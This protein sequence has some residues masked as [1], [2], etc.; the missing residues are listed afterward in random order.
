MACLKFGGTCENFWWVTKIVRTKNGFALTD[1]FAKQTKF[2]VVQ[3][4]PK[5]IRLLGCLSW[6]SSQVFDE[7]RENW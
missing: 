4:G 3:T 6:L 5:F 2:R 7:K 1:G